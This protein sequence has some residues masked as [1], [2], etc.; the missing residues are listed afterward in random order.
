[1]L[2][3]LYIFVNLFSKLIFLL[4]KLYQFVYTQLYIV[5]YTYTYSFVG[6]SFKILSGELFHVIKYTI[7]ISPFSFV[8]QLGHCCILF[9]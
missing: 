7:N 9:L 5:L 3:I 1:M 4:I 2:T 6:F 8:E